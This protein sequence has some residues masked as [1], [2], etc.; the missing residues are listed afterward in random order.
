MARSDGAAESGFACSSTAV[1]SSIVRGGGTKGR[2]LNDAVTLRASSIDIAV[3]QADANVKRQ[4]TTPMASAR[5]HATL[6]ANRVGLGN[7][8]ISALTGNSDIN[9]ALSAG[10]VVGF[11]YVRASAIVG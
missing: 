1:M 7:R 10:A 8:G 4:T 6:T 2:P 11:L 3:W 5:S 9:H